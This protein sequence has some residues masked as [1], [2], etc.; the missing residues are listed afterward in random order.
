MGWLDDIKADRRQERDAVA[1]RQR[2]QDEYQ[3]GWNRGFSALNRMVKRVLADVGK[4]EWGWW[5][6]SV[7]RKKHEWKVTRVPAER[8]RMRCYEVG[9]RVPH[10]VIRP[11]KQSSPYFEVRGGITIET[12]DVSEAALK[13]AF[14]TCMKEAGPYTINYS[15]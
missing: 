11:S 2:L 4:A 10:E 3:A 1:T 13:A 12:T 9:Y 15:I 14:H 6:Y 5:H 7:S 8:Y